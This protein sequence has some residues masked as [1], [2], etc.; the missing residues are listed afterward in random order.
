MSDL[1]IVIEKI[2]D[3][4]KETEQR[5]KVVNIIEK[6]LEFNTVMD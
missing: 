1:K 2:P 5:D 3:D 4:K 6:I